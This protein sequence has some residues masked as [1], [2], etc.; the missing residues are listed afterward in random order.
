MTHH[1]EDGSSLA[2]FN[3][4]IC[5]DESRALKHTLLIDF[6]QRPYILSVA[7]SNLQTHSLY[8]CFK[9]FLDFFWDFLNT[10]LAHSSK[11]I[12]PNNAYFGLSTK[13]YEL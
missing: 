6:F 10:I 5:L 8:N 2:S 7:F 11:H 12:L 1:L 13:G 3:M 4:R 9:N